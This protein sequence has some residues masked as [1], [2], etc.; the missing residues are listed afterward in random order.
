MGFFE[1]LADEEEGGGVRF[2]ELGFVW[3]VDDDDDDDDDDEVEDNE[4]LR[5]CV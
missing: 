1:R 5:P 3:G 4:G 2:R